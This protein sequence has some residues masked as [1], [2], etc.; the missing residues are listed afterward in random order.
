MICTWDGEPV[1]PCLGTFPAGVFPGVTAKMGRVPRRLLSGSRA[2][3]E[4]APDTPALRARGVG[5]ML[6]SFADTVKDERSEP[7]WLPH[8]H[9]AQSAGTNPECWPELPLS[10][11][12]RQPGRPAMGD[13]P[14]SSPPRSDSEDTVG[15]LLLTACCS[16]PVT[17]QLV[18]SP[19][20]PAPELLPFADAQRPVLGP[21]GLGP[22]RALQFR[23]HKAARWTPHPPHPTAAGPCVPHTP[24]P[25][26]EPMTPC[27]H[28]RT[29]HACSRL[30]G[31]SFPTEARSREPE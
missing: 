5:A 11:A 9:T 30:V 7:P 15:P 23:V 28:T 20:Q 14:A 18:P 21:S 31:F 6:S 1:S 12:L 17:C 3:E 27:V 25:L 16:Q 4:T 24:Q 10:R 26:G 2:D 22:D 8:P 19:E 13:R 29:T